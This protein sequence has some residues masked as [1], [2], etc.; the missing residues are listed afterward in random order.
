MTQYSVYDYTT[1]K[2]E[3]FYK[4]VNAKKRMKELLAEGHNVVG[5]K[6]KVYA[7]GEWEPCG[8][9]T[10]KGSNKT[11]VANTKQAKAGY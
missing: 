5:T 7:N 3:T 9:I 1:N 11:F 8:E 6:T 4:L 10:L 2:S